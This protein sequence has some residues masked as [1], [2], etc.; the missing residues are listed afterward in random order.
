[1]FVFIVF[2]EFDEYRVEPLSFPACIRA[3]AAE[4]VSS[5]LN[6]SREMSADSNGRFIQSDMRRISSGNSSCSILGPNIVEV[7]AASKKEATEYQLKAVYLYNFLLYL[8][9]DK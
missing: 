8:S 6:R 9:K 2:Y 3:L 4:S 1:M 5:V 7:S